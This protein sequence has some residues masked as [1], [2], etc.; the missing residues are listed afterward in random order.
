MPSRGNVLGYK[1]AI[2]SITIEKDIS[3]NS[4]VLSTLKLATIFILLEA[5]ESVGSIK[6]G[7]YDSIAFY[8]LYHATLS[9][10]DYI[11]PKRGIGS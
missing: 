8:L 11:K 9:R 1:S 2:N 10:K 5:I 4:K 6:K 3:S 7:Y